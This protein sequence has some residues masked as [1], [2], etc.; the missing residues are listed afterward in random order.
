MSVKTQSPVTDFSNTEIAFAH[1]TDLE[2]RR[3]AW[4]F[5]MM[6]KPWLVHWGSKLAKWALK[7]RLP[8]VET[9]TMRTIYP[10]FVGGKTLIGLLG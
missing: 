9:I 10:Q 8:F 6:S 4:L 5:R 1:K 2:L 3:M 7:W